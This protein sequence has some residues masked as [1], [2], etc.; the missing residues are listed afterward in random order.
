MC[1]WITSL[2]LV[3]G[4]GKLLTVPKDVSIVGMDEKKILKAAQVNLGVF[5]VVVEYTLTVKKM[6]NCRVK[7][8]F[9]RC[10]GV[11]CML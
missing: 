4:N 3:D 7:N 8:I 5:G 6:T 2:K 11:S 10:L 1:D 9:D